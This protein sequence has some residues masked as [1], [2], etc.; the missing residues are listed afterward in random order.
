LL[1]PILE[2]RAL[3]LAIGGNPNSG[4]TTLFNRLTGLRQKVANYAGA[5]VEKKLGDFSTPLTNVQIIDL[6]GTYGL[7]PK[8]EEE[9]IAAEVILGM[10]REVS[11]PEGV[12]CVVDST[13][14]EKSLY[15][16]LQ[17][18][19]TNIP[20]AVLLNMSDE[21]ELRGAAIDQEKLSS[22][23]GVPVLL[24]S[25]TRDSNLDH[26]LNL[27]D[28]WKGPADS[29]FCKLPVIPSLE[30]VSFRRTKAREIAKAVILKPLQPHP[31]SDKVD[32]VVMHQVWGPLL[33]AAIVML[34]FQSIFSWAQ[35]FMNAIDF[36]F[37][38]FAGFL[39]HALPP[40]FWN[41]FLSD[42]VVAGVG[43][44]VVFLPQILIVFFF[45]AILENV[46]YL[47]RAAAVMD[48]LLHA[49]GLQGKSFLPLIS[50]YACAIPGIM[51][52]RTI[53][54]R[55]DR[56]A[57]IFIA[58]FMTCS[59]RLPVYAL[60]I[61]AFVPNTPIL[62]QFFGLRAMTLLGLYLLG[63]VVALLTALGL[64][65]T[66]LRSKGAPFFLEIPP[67]RIPA[68]KT[69]GILMWDRSKVF[70]AQAGTIIL[71]VNVILW[72][73]ASYPKKDGVVVARESYAGHIGRFIEP[74][75][76]PLGFDWK[77]GV[78]LLSAQA[79]REV[80]ISTL[81]TIYR[82]DVKGEKQE[83]L[84]KA[85][86]KDMTPLA[87]VSLMVFFALA[88]QCTSTLAI[89]RHETGGWK[90]PVIMFIYMNSVAYSASFMVYHFGK[91]L[92]WG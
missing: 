3:T 54:N 38:S 5:T 87:A 21:L 27:I 59:A 82:V 89:V 55:R 11:R 76:R 48:R 92:G 19:D 12:L 34:V 49:M 58:P 23:L 1:T 15:L 75:I 86:R 20:T 26:V 69:I 24:I 62:G 79:A 41:S 77:I 70:L 44:V 2:K 64:K 43:S 9:R 22:L 61:G 85:L 4:K 32:T 40:G 8:S 56:L 68:L 35:P 74:A 65:S 39:K 66:I 63:F 46:G 73:L 13:C 78:G 14:L 50:S 81:G 83:G 51:A 67:Y 47:P 30:E 16:V 84:Q 37:T 28:Q 33:F 10:N 90:I 91:L 45:I 71:L 52:T 7:T 60:L 18:I 53:E 88:M 36:G 31:W 72:F 57:T 25:A 42:G 29:S 17:M 6:P 80:M